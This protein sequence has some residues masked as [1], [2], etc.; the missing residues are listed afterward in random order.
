MK[1]GKKNA[2]LIILKSGFTFCPMFMLFQKACLQASCLQTL[3]TQPRVHAVIEAVAEYLSQLM[4]GTK[5]D[6][7]TGWWE[8]R[9]SLGKE[10]AGLHW[11]SKAVTDANL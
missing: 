11:P 6:G 4:V 3:Q 8:G 7:Q 10:E 5:L 2:E 9:G 1:D